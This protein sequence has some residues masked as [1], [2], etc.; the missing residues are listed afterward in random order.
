MKWA[1]NLLQIPLHLQGDQKKFSAAARQR[2]IKYLERN[3]PKMTDSYELSIVAYALAVSGSAKSDLAYRALKG[4]MKEEGGMIYW[5]RSKIE[6][7][8]VQRV[9]LHTFDYTHYDRLSTILSTFGDMFV[10]LT[11]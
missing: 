6:T 7:N 10:N 2:A 8:K 3:L 11:M 9:L 4:A 5:S 1:V